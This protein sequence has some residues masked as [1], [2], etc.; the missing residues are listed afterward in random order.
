MSFYVV[1][2][3]RH[4]HIA[5]VLAVFAVSAYFVVLYGILFHGTEYGMNGHW[6]DNGNRLALICKMMA[7]NSFFQDWYLKDLPSFY[8]P[9]WFA[10]MALYAKLLGIEAYQTIK[11]GYLFVFLCYPWLLYFSWRRLVSPVAAAAVV[12]ATLFFAHKYLD[13]IYY[14]HMTAALFIPWWLYYFNGVSSHDPASRRG[15]KHYLVGAVGGGLLFMVFYY[16]FFVALVVFPVTLIACFLE[17]RSILQLAREIKHKII[18]MASVALVSSVYWLPLLL[19]IC[20]R[21]TDSAQTQWFGL[22]HANLGGQPI[23]LETVLICLGVFFAFY[24]RRKLGLG[25]LPYLFLGGLLLILLDR[26]MNLNSY[27]LQ[28]RKAIEFVHVF[29]MA[30]LG[31]GIVTIWPSVRSH[32]GLQRGLIGLFVLLSVAVS[33]D[34]TEVYRSPFY[35]TAVGQRVPSRDL[36]V[37][38]AVQSHSAVFLSSHYLECCYLPYYLFIPRNNMT[39]H[40]A[41]RYGQRE[42]FLESAAEITDPVLL[43]YVFAHNRYDRIDYVYLPTGQ[44][45]G[46]FE[47]PLNQTT[48]NGRA[49][50]KT[51]EFA[52]DHTH[53]PEC[54]IKRHDRGVYEVAAPERS[55]AM[56]LL[57]LESNPNVVG[58]LQ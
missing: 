1:Y 41:G 33:N 54:F 9:L 35:K 55:A 58:Q 18:L 53:A 16:W 39:S 23:S 5:P 43:A 13:W 31:V 32:M 44:E 52:A 4:S 36:E 47:V 34:H 8:P 26:L 51:I 49:Q 40:T 42:G 2:W 37:F 29:A 20:R 50:T 28:S 57:L 11:W 7:Y 25:K 12:I 48:F 46:R 15:W 14:E 24:L 45:T 38:D 21:G 3:K 56:D 17:E 6:G 22:R 10:M 19:S 30:P 27:S